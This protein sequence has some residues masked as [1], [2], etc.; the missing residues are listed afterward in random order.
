M[1]TTIKLSD[2]L[3]REAKTVG[4][5]M[6]RSAPKQLEHWARIGRIA[7][8]NPEL[9]Y[10]EIQGILLAEQEREDELTDY[11]FLSGAG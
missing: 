5:A 7:E 10:S 11:T 3:I 2:Q 1:A 4:Q 9:T 8:E 6:S